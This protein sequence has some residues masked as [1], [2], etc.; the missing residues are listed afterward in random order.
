MQ[1]N[2]PTQ[3]NVQP[4]YRQPVPVPQGGQ[5][6]APP[7]KLMNPPDPSVLLPEQ[8]I[9]LPPRAQIF[10]PIRNERQLE[11]W[12]MEEVRASQGLKP[13][14]QLQFPN[15]EII[16][17]G[18]T[19]KPKTSQYPPQ[20]VNFENTY[21]VYRRPLFEELNA[22]RYGWDLG[23][24]QPLVSTMYFYKDVIALP[25]N[26]ASGC[27]Q[28]F[29]DTSAGKC[30]PGSPVPYCLYPQGLSITGGAFEGTVWTALGVI[31]H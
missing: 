3:G 6:N 31:V 15:E 7:G 12:I 8:N 25:Y 18:I 14:E 16:G 13:T 24:I 27:T 9:N 17:L 4:G 22:E 30:L 20:K 19:Y 28:G 29:W 26:F 10:G 23:I 21:Q 11:N 2:N 1:P 5:G